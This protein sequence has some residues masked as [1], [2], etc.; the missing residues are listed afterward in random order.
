MRFDILTLFPSFFETPLEQSI[1]KR[2]KEKGVTEYYIHDIRAFADE[3]QKITDDRP[4]GGGPGM[5]LKVEPIDR[6]LKHIQAKKNTPN[7][8]IILTSA[9][10][11]QYTQE[12][13]KKWSVLERVVVIC[14]HYEG[15]DERVAE[16]LIDEE[17]R[18]GEYVL[19]GGEPAALVFLDSLVRLQAGV[20]GNSGSIE[21]ESHDM[22]GKL[23]YPQYTRPRDYNG[24]SVPDILVTGDHQKITE[25][26]Q[27]QER[28][29]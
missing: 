20:L 23:S 6:A 15:V 1:L 22:P 5:V 25:W 28:Q 2:A 29:D 8:K 18:I 13:A 10:G 14:G 3:P 24:W 7:E 9:K 16:H 19:T 4:F 11:T 21:N 27:A 17:V 12:T 26:R